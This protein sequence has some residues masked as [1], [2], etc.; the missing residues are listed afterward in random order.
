MLRSSPPAGNPDADFPSQSQLPTANPARR[1]LESM[2]DP[3]NPAE[4]T[5]AA[6][7]AQ[8][9]GPPRSSGAAAPL[10]AVLT[11]TFFG[12]LGTAIVT[13]GIYFIAAASYG[14]T[15]ADNYWLGLVQG[16][17]YIVGALGAGPMLRILRTRWG[18]STRA[19]LSWVM[20]ILGMLCGIPILLG[21]QGAD[22]SQWP[23]WLLVVLY[24]PLTGMLWPIVE[25]YL[26]GGRRGGALRFALGRFNITWSSALVLGLVVIGPAVKERSP[27]L[28][29]ALGIM[30]IVSILLLLKMGREPGKHLHEVHEP[31]PIVYTQLLA[32][33]RIL[34]PTSYIVFTALNPYL[35][36]LLGFMGITAGWQAPLAATWGA[37]RVGTF[38]LLERWHGWHGRWYPA[39]IGV[40]LLLGGFA[41][42]VLS[43][44]VGASLGG[45][46]LALAG[47]AAFGVGMASIYTGALYYALEVGQAEVEAGGTHE[48]LIGLGYTGGPACALL[49]MGAAKQELIPTTESAFQAAVLALVAVIALTAAGFAAWR[50]WRIARR[51]LIF[52]G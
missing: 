33:F 34:L 22:A 32:T 1:G 50:S 46:A 29:A 30:H 49:A 11:F 5:A 16:G 48:A 43:P 2:T 41:A 44:G 13:T 9:V 19:A 45:Q 37:A 17:T 10:W 42:A 35:P 12:S 7:A 15:K 18:I 4:A 8:P 40:V 6:V 28:I 24:S 26:S 23:L 38:I 51:G 52:G 36:K 47:L 20:L 21:R 25:S 14:F 39:V 27:E 31:H 3:V